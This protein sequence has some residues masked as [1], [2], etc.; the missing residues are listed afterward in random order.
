MKSTSTI[1]Q[2]I[3]KNTKCLIVKTGDWLTN[4]NHSSS[5]AC[6]MALPMFSFFVLHSFLHFRVGDLRYAHYGFGSRLG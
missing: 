3:T 4:P 2:A 1:N 5:N 6:I